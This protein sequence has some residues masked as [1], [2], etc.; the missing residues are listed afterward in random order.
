MTR[1]TRVAIAAAV[2]LPLVATSA[3]PVLAQR[4]AAVPLQVD[5]VLTRFSGD[6]QVSSLPFTLLVNADEPRS[7]TSIRMGVQVPI[8]TTKDGAVS[9]TYQNVGTQID[10]MAES[11]ADGFNL[12]L[13]INDSSLYEPAQGAQASQAQ[14]VGGY[15]VIRSFYSQ[16]TVG[17]KDG[18]T[19]QYTM[20]T[21]K[22]SGETMKVNVTVKALR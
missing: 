5:V 22:I 1:H 11:S 7:R 20:A 3:T 6:K 21:D 16:T 12:N 17:I 4:P 15:P 8:P 10:C 2:L 9:I 18:Q 14:A 13:S 19:M